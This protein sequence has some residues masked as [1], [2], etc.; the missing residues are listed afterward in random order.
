[1]ESHMHDDVGHNFQQLTSL[2]KL[3]PDVVDFDVL[4][5]GLLL[6][7]RIVQYCIFSSLF[8]N[9][10]VTDGSGD[11][12]DD[13]SEDWERWAAA[14]TQRRVK[15]SITPC[16]VGLVSGSQKAAYIIGE[17]SLNTEY[18]GYVYRVNPV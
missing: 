7:C 17:L 4:S 11:E 6:Q 10:C 1:M 16:P 14:V 12:R 8:S 2:V 13:L 9:D 3:Q 18:G 15:E 5:W